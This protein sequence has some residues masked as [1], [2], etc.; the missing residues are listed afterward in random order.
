VFAT[1]VVDD[2]QTAAVL[3]VAEVQAIAVGDVRE[4]AGSGDEDNGQ[5]RR[6]K[7]ADY[8][9]TVSLKSNLLEG[10]LRSFAHCS[11]TPRMLRIGCAYALTLS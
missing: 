2:P 11:A 9:A 5:D 10:H 4:G 7:N 8:P 6:H 1:L 3:V